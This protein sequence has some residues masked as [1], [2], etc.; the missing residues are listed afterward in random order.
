MSE[1]VTAPATRQTAWNALG[2]L[3]SDGMTGQEA[4]TQA[5]LANWNVRKAPLQMMTED[6]I[7]SI[8]DRFAIVRD[9]RSGVQYIPGGVVGSNY[10]PIQ[11]EANVDLLDAIVDQGGAHFTA[12]GSTGNGAKTFVAMDVP[13]GIQV[14]GVDPVGLNLVAINNHV[15]AGAF[16]FLV[17]PVRIACTNMLAAAQR[18]AHSTFSIR[19][20]SGATNRVIAEARQALDLT[21][22]YADEFAADAERLIEQSMTNRQFDAWA[23]KLLK[24]D[25]EATARSKNKSAAALDTMKSLWRESPTLVGIDHTRWAAY[26]VFT[27]FTDHLAPVKATAGKEDP[28]FARANRSVMIQTTVAAK[29]KAFASLLPA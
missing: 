18:E 25:A 22:A 13:S 1:L 20:T 21:F 24:V 28:A 23:A 12:A 10:T 14:G 27:E 4:L 15:G 3:I 16:R 17:T 7:T 9:T 8:P 26:N 11:N 5:G 29:E 2:V 6:G 19:H